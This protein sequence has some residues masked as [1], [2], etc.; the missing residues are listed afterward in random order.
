[1]VLIHEKWEGRVVT[2]CPGVG[3]V[4]WLRGSLNGSE[5]R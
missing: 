1:M 3:G 2:W 5:G 4:E